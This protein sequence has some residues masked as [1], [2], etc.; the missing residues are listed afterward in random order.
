MQEKTIPS[1]ST[2]VTDVTVE[3]L[4]PFSLIQKKKGFSFRVTGDT[5]ELVD[6][7]LPLSKKTGEKTVIDLGTG[8]GV[9]PLLLAWKSPVEKIVGVEID[10]DT[11]A[12]AE[13]NIRMNGLT[14]R[15][16]IIEKDWRM[17]E[18]VFPEGAFEVV[19]SNPPYT[20]KGAGRAS[21][22]KQRAIARGEVMG[23]LAEL[24]RVSTHLAG[25]AGRIFFM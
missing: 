11:A 5:F 23:T 4:G 12:L 14:S 18:G 19:I 7:V 9:I 3:P 22:V 21:P 20:K 16:T 1:G 24:L 8:T 13:K 6:F 10:K 17:L 15:V 2:D 25:P